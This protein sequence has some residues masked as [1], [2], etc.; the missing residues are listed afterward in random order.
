M[1]IVNKIDDL[2]LNPATLGFHCTALIG[3]ENELLMK[4]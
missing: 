3:R 1:P 2:Q 4:R